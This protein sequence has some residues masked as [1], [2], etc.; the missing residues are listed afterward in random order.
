MKKQT[1]RMMLLLTVLLM[2]MSGHLMAQEG[3]VVALERN[4]THPQ[5]MT[6]LVLWPDE[7]E[8]RKSTYGKSIQLEFSYCLPCKVVTGCRG[9]GTINYDWS[10]F[11]QLLDDVASRGHQLVARF[12][13]EYPSGTDVDGKKGTTAVPAYIKQRSDYMRP[14]PATQEATDLRTMPTGAMRSCSALRCS[15][16]PTSASDT[17]MMPV[18]HFWKWASVIGRNITSTARI[19]SLV[20]TSPRR[21]S[22][23]SSFCT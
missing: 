12:R 19:C 5:P 10:W 18:W 3:N 8:D 9:D 20:S 13:Y 21:L 1:H 17:A 15:S 4:I 16:I 14:T 2:G 6:G 11:E 22:S 7:A 23:V